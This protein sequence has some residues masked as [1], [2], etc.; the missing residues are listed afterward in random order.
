MNTNTLIEEVNLTELGK[1]EE[2][3]IKLRLEAA[4][5]KLR[6]LEIKTRQ[7]ELRKT[8]KKKKMKENSPAPLKERKETRKDDTCSNNYYNK[9]GDSSESKNE[10]P[11]EPAFVPPTLNEVQAY[12]DEIGENRF[13]A[14]KFW[15]YYEAKGWVLGKSKMKFWKRVLDNWSHAENG[16]SRRHRGIKTSA[17]QQNIVTFNPYK[18]ID[19]TGTVNLIEYERMV[20]EGKLQQST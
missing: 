16:R 10:N 14:I 19:T 20:K 9:K 6:L 7:Q 12:M 3:K 13:S 17:S 4:E 5:L 8:E 2:E 11:Q 1:T 18:P 15:N